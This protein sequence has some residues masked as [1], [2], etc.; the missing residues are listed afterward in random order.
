[1]FLVDGSLVAVLVLLYMI[2]VIANGCCMQCKYTAESTAER[3]ISEGHNIKIHKAV[4]RFFKCRDCGQRTTSLN[5]LP[6][7]A[8]RYVL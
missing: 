3:C 8:C 1:L 4:K 7:V 2:V 6:K 5:K